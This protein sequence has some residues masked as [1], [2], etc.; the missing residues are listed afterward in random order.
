MMRK[1][2]RGIAGGLYHGCQWHLRLLPEWCGLHHLWN[3]RQRNPLLTLL[4]ISLCYCF[5]Y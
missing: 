2:L 3:C 5:T 4:T 1:K